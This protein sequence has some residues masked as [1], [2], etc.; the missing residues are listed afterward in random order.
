MGYFQ[1]GQHGQSSGEENTNGLK[2]IVSHQFE[3]AYFKENKKYFTNCQVSTKK[4]REKL[5]KILEISMSN[6]LE[7]TSTL[8]QQEL[9]DTSYLFKVEFNDRHLTPKSYLLNNIDVLKLGIK[10]FQEKFHRN[11]LKSILR[12]ELDQKVLDVLA[13]RYWKDDNLQD[14]SSSKL[15]SDT[16]MLY[17]HK[18]W[19]SHHPA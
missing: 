15:E 17:W 18:N 13:T 4:L 11:E 14:L 19:N 8:I 2:Q 9:D 5:I 16:D 12:A 10:E 1:K 7:P 3:K 6:A